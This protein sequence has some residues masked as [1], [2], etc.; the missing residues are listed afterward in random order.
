MSL[1]EGNMKPAPAAT[2]A[3]NLGGTMA[4]AVAPAPTEAEVEQKASESLNVAQAGAME[5]L[6]AAQAAPQVGEETE[7]KI[8]NAVV[9]LDEAKNEIAASGAGTGPVADQGNNMTPPPGVPSGGE[10]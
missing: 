6:E 5:A 4:P 2:T 1:P 9:L 8:E 10:G 3:G 7:Q